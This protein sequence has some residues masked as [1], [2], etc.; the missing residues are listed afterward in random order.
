MITLSKGGA[1]LINGN[2]IIEDSND[3]LLA[4]KSKTGKDVTKVQFYDKKTGNSVTF[5]KDNAQITTVNGKLEWSFTMNFTLGYDQNYV[6]RTRTASTSF[7]DTDKTVSV[8]VV[9]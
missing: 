2:E 9:Y 4:I 1:F 3:A 6:I 5:T 8:S 7:A